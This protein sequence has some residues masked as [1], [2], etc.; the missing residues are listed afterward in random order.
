MN[1]HFVRLTW[2][3]K[4]NLQIKSNQLINKK[5]VAVE[6]VTF[7]MFSVRGSV[8]FWFW[9]ASLLKSPLT[10]SVK[11]VTNR[12]RP[13]KTICLEFAECQTFFLVYE[14]HIFQAPP[15]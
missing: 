5:L 13:G 12:Y 7:Y 11:K 14:Q 8:F 6:R 2:K 4:K 10:A 15:L 3:E 9:C 1:L